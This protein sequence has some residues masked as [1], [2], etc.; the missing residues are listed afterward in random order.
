MQWKSSISSVLLLIV[1]SIYSSN[2]KENT[3]IKEYIINQ[4]IADSENQYNKETVKGTQ[5]LA[6]L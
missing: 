6:T 1:T 3:A 4:I 5:N 2:S